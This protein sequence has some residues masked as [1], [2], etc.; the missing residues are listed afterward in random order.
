V[1]VS[2]LAKSPTLF[3]YAILAPLDHRTDVVGDFT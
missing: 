3:G 2:F 1:C